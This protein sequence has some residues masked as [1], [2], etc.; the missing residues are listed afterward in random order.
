M[1]ANPNNYRNAVMENQVNFEH[2]LKAAWSGDNIAEAEFFSKLYVRF[3]PLITGELQR[4]PVLKKSMDIEN[5]SRQV[6]QTTINNLKRLFPLTQKKW[7]MQ[8]AVNVLH[9]DIDDF[10]TKAL[11]K[12]ARAGDTAA[13]NSLFMMIRKKLMERITQKRKRYLQ[14]E[15]PNG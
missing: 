6:I 13:E 7:S 12:L 5:E 3:L 14:Y 10:I 8:S 15:S 4:H 1:L 9:N 2:L 11:T